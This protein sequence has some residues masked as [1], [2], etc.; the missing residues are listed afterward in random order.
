M[1]HVM[2]GASGTAKA[3]R[4]SRFNRLRALIRRQADQQI[5]DLLVHLAEKILPMK[6][7]TFR[8]IT[9]TK[10]LVIE[11][12]PD[13]IRIDAVLPGIVSGQAILVCG[14][15]KMLL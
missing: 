15:T 5:G 14:D 8:G 3:S 12:G 4:L 10:S 2:S 1:D 13:R 6:P 7:P 11:L 9:R